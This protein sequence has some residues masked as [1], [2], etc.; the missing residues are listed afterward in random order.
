MPSVRSSFVAGDV[1][2]SDAESGPSR[3][4]HGAKANLACRSHH[5]NIDHACGPLSRLIRRS[6]SASRS[7]PLGASSANSSV[8]RLR[9]RPIAI[10]KSGRHGRHGDERE[11]SADQTGAR[12]RQPRRKIRWHISPMLASRMR[13]NRRAALK[14]V[15]LTPLTAPVKAVSVPPWGAFDAGMANQRIR[16]A[17]PTPTRSFEI[18][19]RPYATS[20]WK[21]PG[22]GRAIVIRAEAH[23]HESPLDLQAGECV[24]WPG[25]AHSESVVISLDDE[26]IADLAVDGRS[27]GCL[28]SVSWPRARPESERETVRLIGRIGAP[29]AKSICKR[30]TPGVGSSRL[31]WRQRLC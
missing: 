11:A 16:T 25:D 31:P 8:N 20:H 27:G 3:R 30:A 24:P 4:G 19:Q 28:G 6:R 10:A 29:I 9:R 23:W 7:G 21:R 18:E 17:R 22:I 5:W 26:V 1:V 15:I 2:P 14:V 13:W 12:P